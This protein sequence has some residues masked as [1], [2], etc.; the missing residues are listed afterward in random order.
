MNPKKIL[1]CAI[2]A[3]ALCWPQLSNAQEAATLPAVKVEGQVQAEPSPSAPVDGYKA[4][5]TFSATKTGTPIVETQQSISVITRDRIEDQG[6]LTLQDALGYTAGVSAGSY[7]FDNRGDWAFIRGTSFVQYQDGLKQLFGF[8]NN[9][10]PDP[11]T[12]ERV[13]VVKGPSSVLYGQGGFGGLVNMVSK[14]PQREQAGEV[15]VQLGEYGRKQLALDLTGTLNEDGTLLYRM[16]ALTRDSDSQVNFV[17]DDRDLFAPAITWR[18]NADTSL[19]AYLNV[20]RDVSGS[21]VGFFPIIGTRFEGPN[22]RIPTN[23]F[24]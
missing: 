16:I 14:R 6:A 20:Q 15:G 12:L 9:V 8:Y 11:F 19:T 24:I 2:S 7:G 22:G 5:S 17:P 4:N 23:T 1:P 3:I 21:S 18:P 13:E 10:R